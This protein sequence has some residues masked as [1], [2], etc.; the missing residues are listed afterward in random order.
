[1]ADDARRALIEVG[2]VFADAGSPSAT[3]GFD[4]VTDA[5]HRMSVT[6]IEMEIEALQ[7]ACELQQSVL[8][9]LYLALDR[10]TFG[11]REARTRVESLRGELA[12]RETDRSS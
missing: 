8:G 12:R 9:E 3:G 5:P 6:E 10:T 7:A 4:V 11:L 1:M 2:I